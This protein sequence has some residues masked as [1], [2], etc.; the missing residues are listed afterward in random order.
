MS[1]LICELGWSVIVHATYEAKRA[2]KRTSSHRFIGWHVHGTRESTVLFGYR[3]RRGSRRRSLRM[4]WARVSS[5]LA[6]FTAAAGKH[7]MTRLAPPCHPFACG[8]RL[9]GYSG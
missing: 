1:G 7:A 6:L 8:A 3:R 2:A 4:R 9:Q 5:L